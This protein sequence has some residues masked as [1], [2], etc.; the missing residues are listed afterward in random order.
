MTFRKIKKKEKKK[1]KRTDTEESSVRSVRLK[2][3]RIGWAIKR[4]F[5][6]NSRATRGPETVAHLQH[7]LRDDFAHGRRDLRLHTLEVRRAGRVSL[8]GFQ[9]ILQHT[10]VVEQDRIRV[11]SALGVGSFAAQ[12]IHVP[13]RSFLTSL[14]TRTTREKQR[15][16][17]NLSR[18][19]LHLL[20]LLHRRPFLLSLN[21][22]RDDCCRCCCYCCSTIEHVLHRGARTYLSRFCRS[23]TRNVRKS[24]WWARFSPA[25]RFFRLLSPSSPSPSPSSSSSSSRCH[26][27][28]APRCQ[29]VFRRRGQTEH[30]R[31]DRKDTGAAADDEK[32]TRIR[33]SAD[34]LPTGPGTLLSNYTSQSTTIQRRYTRVRAC[35]RY[36]CTRTRS[37]RTLVSADDFRI[38]LT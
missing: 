15:W 2:E 10:I 31:I 20:L 6:A 11:R 21:C 33:T 5:R 27:I 7:P 8:L 23:T 36:A 16:R 28:H 38:S 14:G 22:V 29:T 32:F 1:E 12:Q 37:N 9:E 17:Y 25:V 24:P 35:V 3:I 30:A 4:I 19:F 18:F 34:A 26:F 13:R